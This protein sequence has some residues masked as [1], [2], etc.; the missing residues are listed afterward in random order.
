MGHMPRV[1]SLTLKPKLCKDCDFDP[2]HEGFFGSGS[3]WPKSKNEWLHILV[4]I[5]ITLGEQ[6]LAI[7]YLN[8]FYLILT[9]IFIKNMP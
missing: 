4:N 9:T 5:A 2:Y 8:I 6:V 1:C 3:A 7:E